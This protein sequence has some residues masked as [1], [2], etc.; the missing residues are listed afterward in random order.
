MIVDVCGRHG[1]WFDAD[2][3][4]EL[5]AWVRS[6]GLEVA[7]DDLARLRN[8]PD[9]VRRRAL[10]NRDKQQPPRAPSPSASDVPVDDTDAPGGIAILGGAVET[11]PIVA[12]ALAWIF[13]RI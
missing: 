2:E 4:T 6:G 11:V 12:E 3:L 13:A 9:K 10:R 8:A 5:L 1:V 7:R